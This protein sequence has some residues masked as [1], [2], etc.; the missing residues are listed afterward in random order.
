[1][2]WH[3]AIVNDYSLYTTQKSKFSILNFISLE[4]TIHKRKKKLLIRWIYDSSL[5]PVV[6]DDNRGR[7]GRLHKSDVSTIMFHVQCP[8]VS[9]E[10]QR[11]GIQL[12]II[13]VTQHLVDGVESKTATF[14]VGIIAMHNASPGLR[15]RL[16]GG[17]HMETATSHRLADKGIESGVR[18]VAVEGELVLVHKTV[19]EVG[20]LSGG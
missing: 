7:V 8:W 20:C 3:Q 15:E 19:Y 17:A 10:F 13:L 2:K 4:Y 11:T 14:C 18:I 16:E 9:M 1:M 6:L 12:S 5:L